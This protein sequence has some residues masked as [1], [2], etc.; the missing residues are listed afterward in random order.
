MRDAQ[1]AFDQVIS[2]SG[3]RIATEDVEAALG[4][5]STELLRRTM[6][7]I[8]DQTPAETIAVVEDLTMRGHDLRNFTRDLLAYVRD[9]LTMRIA[10]EVARSAPAGDAEATVER[11]ASELAARFSES[12]LVRF[13]HSLTQTE[14]D[15]RESAHPRYQLE[16]GLVKL[17]EM[18][19]LA[20]LDD[21]LNRLTQLEQ[22]MRGGSASL[23]S[24]GGGSGAPPV[25][26]GGSNQPSRRA[27]GGG[28]PRPS[29][30]PPAVPPPVASA[31][32]NELS[33]PAP[34]ALAPTATAQGSAP[35]LKLVTP[36]SSPPAG[37]ESSA[38]SESSSFTLSAS[39]S[40]PDAPLPPA[41][42]ITP[43]A[44]ASAPIKVNAASS[45]I[46]RIIAELE[47]R[48]PFVAF[49]LGE[50]QRITIEGNELSIV[51]TPKTR[52]LR[53]NL[54]QP[55][56]RKALIEVCREV[57]GCDIGLKIAVRDPQES[58]EGS[59]QESEQEQA[60]RQTEEERAELWRIAEANPT[61]QEFKRIFRG[62]I[63]DVWR[64]PTEGSPDVQC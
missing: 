2:F 10:H 46:E 7:A 56:S 60:P 50:A 40:P 45:P 11:A 18:G 5:A 52:H 9:L 20:R 28:A 63:L 3:E 62:E 48:R 54:T 23:S 53:D 17:I 41:A 13:F 51:L 24:V 4:L 33:V 42:S 61:I 57:T 34:G 49:A 8:A 64:E 35:P 32:N 26:G 31:Q 37:A 36:V 19:K 21:V 38:F 44:V 25:S 30:A 15:L 27:G 22:R 55:E 29:F 43:S 59:E 14:K 58:G 39:P 12:D 6:R 1:S 47:R 16:V